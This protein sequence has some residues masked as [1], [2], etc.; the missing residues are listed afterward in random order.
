MNPQ[1]LQSGS[2]RI[3]YAARPGGR[4]LSVGLGLA[5]VAAIAIAIYV[6]AQPAARPPVADNPSLPVAQSVPDAA[7]QGVNDYLR[8]HSAGQAAA[9][10]GQ[11]APDANAQAVLDYLRAHEAGQAAASPGQA[12]P[13]ANVQAVLDYLRAHGASLQ[14]QDPA[15]CAAPPPVAGCH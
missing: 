5:A 9:S 12:V 10:Q 13:D 6:A 14:R 1:Q 7:V 11:A 15:P 8:A 4:W 2:K 3:A